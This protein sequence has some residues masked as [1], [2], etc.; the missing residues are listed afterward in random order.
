ML[1]PS[2]LTTEQQVTRVEPPKGGIPFHLKESRS[3]SLG[4]FLQHSLAHMHSLG[5][6]LGNCNAMHID[7]VSQ[8]V[9]RR[10]LCV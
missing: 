6:S 4:S 3:H 5:K 8:S 7:H 2:R 9:R 10:T 1:S